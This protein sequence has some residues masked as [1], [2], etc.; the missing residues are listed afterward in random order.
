MRPCGSTVSANWDI[1]ARYVTR[2]YGLTCVFVNCQFL[3]A[4]PILAVGSVLVLT[5]LMSW[6]G[7]SNRSCSACLALSSYLLILLALAELILAIVIF[8]Q[9][10]TIDQFLKD[11][12][13]ELKLT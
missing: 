7:A 1:C 2:L 6:C 11:H 8:T 13:Q 4:A 10:A 9:G 12:Q 5:A 3:C